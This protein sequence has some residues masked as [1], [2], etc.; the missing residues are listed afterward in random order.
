MLDK[1]RKK[2]KQEKRGKKSKKITGGSDLWTKLKN[3]FTGAKD[4]INETAEQFSKVKTAIQQNITTLNKSLNE[5]LPLLDKCSAALK[6]DPSTTRELADGAGLNYVA[7]ALPR[8]EQKIENPQM[9]NPQMANP[10]MANIQRQNQELE[11]VEPP[12]ETEQEDPVSRFGG[13]QKKTR[14]KR[15]KKVKK[16]D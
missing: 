11:R 5:V 1:S 7:P 3:F 14:K 6:V 15:Q 9:A 16:T 10:Q 12:M 13:A 4:N 8:P 2:Q